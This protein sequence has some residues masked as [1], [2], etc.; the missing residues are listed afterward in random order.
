MFQKADLLISYYIAH[1]TEQDKG[2]CFDLRKS[3]VLACILFADRIFAA[4]NND[5]FLIA[6]SQRSDFM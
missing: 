3:Q 6:G 1:K 5:P 4:D 2:A